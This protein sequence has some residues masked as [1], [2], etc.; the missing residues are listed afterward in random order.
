MAPDEIDRIAARIEQQ[1]VSVADEVDAWRVTIAIDRNLKALQ[2][3]REAATWAHRATGAVRSCAEHASVE[4]PDEHVTVVARSAAEVSRALVVGDACL[5]E[6]G[7]LLR[8]W[9]SYLTD[10]TRHVGLTNSVSR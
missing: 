1:H 10:V 2:R 5:A 6:L 9:S 7:W 4:M 8:A 3:S